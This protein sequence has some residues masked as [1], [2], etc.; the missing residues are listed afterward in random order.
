MYAITIVDLHMGRD[1]A[2]IVQDYLIADCRP[3]MD[4]IIKKMNTRTV[5]RITD[6]ITN[7][8]TRWLMAIMNPWQNDGQI[9]PRVQAH[10]AILD[11]DEA[12]HLTLI[13]PE[14]DR[15][16]IRYRKHYVNLSHPIGIF[17]EAEV[18]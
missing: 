8:D 15:Y 11:Q 1:V 14:D 17:Y 7:K 10:A 18:E 5:W 6:K 12:Y 4:K 16:D 13:E 3:A 9:W 2:S